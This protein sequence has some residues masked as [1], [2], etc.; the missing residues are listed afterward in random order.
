[1]GKT[2]SQADGGLYFT[3]QARAADSFHPAPLYLL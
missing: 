3:A 2:D 1:M